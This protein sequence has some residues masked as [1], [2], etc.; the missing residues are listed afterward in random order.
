MIV[1]PKSL[2][3]LE[4]GPTLCYLS[5]HCFFA[6]SIT[7]A[8][9]SRRIDQMITAGMRISFLASYRCQ[10]RRTK[11]TTN[12][13]KAPGRGYNVVERGSQDE[14]ERV[15]FDLQHQGEQRHDRVVVL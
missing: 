9:R 5:A 11:R 2:K 14:T 3:D 4:D 12:H 1:A 7:F 15:I 6:E 13:T 10:L 8:G